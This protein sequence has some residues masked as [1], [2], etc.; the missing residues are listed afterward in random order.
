VRRLS[1]IAVLAASG[2]A[3]TPQGLWDGQVVVNDVAVPF[4]MEFSGSD[5]AFAGSFFNGDE[6]ITS[7]GGQIRDGVATLDFPYYGKKLQATLR[8]DELDGKFGLPGKEYP[9]H[10]VPHRA[11]PSVKGRVPAIAG[12]WEIPVNNPHEKTWRMVI[13]QTG[14]EVSGAILRLDGDTGALTGEYRDGSFLLSHFAGAAPAVVKVTPGTNGTLALV[15]DGK[16]ELT[17]YRP[18]AARARGLAPPDDPETATTLKNPKEPL[19]F[20][21]PDLSGRMVSNTDPP[22][23]GKVILVEISGS[24]CPN[25]HDEAPLLEE[26]YRRYHAQGLEVV[27]LSFELEDQLKTLDSVRAFVRRYGIGYNV[28]VPGNTS[29]VEAKLPQVQNFGAF[30]TTFFIGRD[31]LV[32]SIHTGFAAKATGDLHDELVGQF[33]STIRRLLA[34]KS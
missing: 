24:W 9:F 26:L 6:R 8:A 13:R 14:R 17:A 28:L 19:Q 5:A 7:T 20:Y 33:T 1:L 15:L 25:C 3:A 30:P 18:P 10:A 32:H 11:L 29:E 22:F 34:D 4:R 2:W 16:T 12:S 27:E 31:G 23:K 21:F